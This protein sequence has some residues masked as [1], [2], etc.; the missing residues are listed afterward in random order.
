MS[1]THSSITLSDLLKLLKRNQRLLMYCSLA[2]C[3]LLSLWTL[4]RPVM[5][6]SEA[7]FQ[8]KGV[9]NN[10]SSSM[11]G[12]LGM[13]AGNLSA[14]QENTIPLMKSRRIWTPIIERY[15]LQGQIF[16]VTNQSS[17][18]TK[19]K[20]NI[21]IEKAYF[22]GYM[23][24]LF[25][26]SS[27]LFLTDL[28]YLSEGPTNLKIEF[29]SNERFI[30]KTASNRPLLEGA[31][32]ESIETEQ[33]SFTLHAEEDVKG[34]EFIIRLDTLQNTAKRVIEQLKIR[35]DEKSTKVLKLN[36]SYRDRLLSSHLLNDLMAGY[37]DYL[38]QEHEQVATAQLD[39][40]EKR[41]V[42]S[43]HNLE[44]L[45]TDYA[46]QLSQEL[47][48]S[49]IIDSEKELAL[50]EEQKAK[51]RQSLVNIELEIS[52]IEK[53][54]E[55]DSYLD[56][57]GASK[58]LPD[59]VLKTISTINEL[60]QRRDRLIIALSPS[61]SDQFA[62]QFDNQ[63]ANLLRLNDE[64][65]HIHKLHLSL[66]REDYPLLLQ[67]LS[68]SRSPILTL[69]YEKLSRAD[70]DSEAGIE[71]TTHFRGY[72][73]HYLRIARVN[74]R[75]M[76]ERLALQQSVDEQLQGM[77]LETST[78]IYLE[79]TH[80]L[81]DTQAEFRQNSFILD[82]M[83]DS[84]FEISSL[85]G[86]LK[87]PVSRALIEKYSTLSM[88]LK[89]SSIRSSKEQDR[90]REELENNRTFLLYHLKQAN[91]LLQ[92]R[93][94]FLDQKIESIQIAMLDLIQQQVS[95]LEKHLQEYAEGHVEQL[96]QKRSFLQQYLRDIR[97]QM[98]SLPYKWGAEQM[99]KYQAK[100]NGAI[101]EEVS[102][103]VETK[104]IAHHLETIQS[105]P[106]DVAATPVLPK[107]PLLAL[108]ALLGLFLGAGFGVLFTVWN[109]FCRG[110]DVSKDTLHSAGHYFA[111]YLP[112][113]LVEDLDPIRKV[114]THL[115]CGSKD[116]KLL[117]LVS[118]GVDYSELLAS[119][120]A[121]KGAKVL[122]LPLCF[123]E[124]YGVSAAGLLQT[125][126]GDVSYPR[127]LHREGFDSIEPGGYSL[128][129]H[130]LLQSKR[131]NQLIEDFSSRYDWIVATHRASPTS[132]EAESLCHLFSRVAVTLS[133]EKVEDLHFYETQ[134]SHKKIAF[135]LQ[136]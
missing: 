4:T 131:F 32:G 39:Y 5:Y 38:Q 108:F 29:L 73:N 107:R 82:Q 136:N 64:L 86:V 124:K 101:V 30:L 114:A 7:S 111:G 57:I 51:L 125:L 97:E 90:I 33:F 98:S 99:I 62:K 9:S 23:H 1:Y 56:S 94:E 24:P 127:I 81:S 84:S 61:S 37:Q 53:S 40:L 20:K 89:D 92:L 48:Q 102:K 121:K 129:G 49:G 18:L 87:D 41:R 115:C 85:S 54:G 43:S 100:I 75:L 14:Q 34:R 63:I 118:N 10:S 78:A 126:E 93:E 104:N 25:S 2:G 80:A 71:Y 6:L 79:F 72:L 132:A 55:T 12:F 50:L 44:Q 95:I 130:E 116:K 16:E 76:E 28:R 83:S 70:L 110:I 122:H 128:Y 105:S 15:S 47:P 74:Q 120:L 123:D 67:L 13:L 17:L 112:S 77:D 119:L 26:D 31:L 117:L 58:D 91:Q 35:P 134:L 36:F 42:N 69:W 3:M 88:S 60:K 59:L 52:R 109:M 68:Q 113:R 66:E 106:I 19:I 65:D 96:K 22:L 27:P 46:A 103:L 21:E 133:T 135:L 11:I 8:E 45:I